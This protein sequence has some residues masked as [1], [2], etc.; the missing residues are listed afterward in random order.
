MSDDLDSIPVKHQQSANKVRIPLDLSKC[1]ICQKKHKNKAISQATSKGIRNIVDAAVLRKDDV[2]RLFSEEFK[3]LTTLS[4]STG[5]IYHRNCFK[6]YVSKMNLSF[7]KLEEDENENKGKSKQKKPQYSGRGMEPPRYMC[8]II[9]PVNK[10]DQLYSLPKKVPQERQEAS[11]H[12]IYGEN[13]E[14]IE[15]CAKEKWSSNDLL[16]SS[17]RFIGKRCSLSFF[18]L[19]II[20]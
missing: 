20:S 15:C 16:N 6:S 2:Y 3:D 14:V 13:W 17:R 18:M 9:K 1:V 11:S 7:A 12:W 19:I 4:E 5:L 10:L 8:R